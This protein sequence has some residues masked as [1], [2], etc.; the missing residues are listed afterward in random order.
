M[1]NTGFPIKDAWL[2]KLKKVPILLID[3]WKGKRIESFDSKYFGNLFASF[4]ENPSNNANYCM[5]LKLR[6]L[7]GQANS[8]NKIRY[9]ALYRLIR[10]QQE[11]MKQDEE[12]LI[13]AYCL[14]LVLR[15]YAVLIPL[16]SESTR[17]NKRKSSL[18]TENQLI[19]QTNQSPGQKQQYLNGQMNG[20]QR[21]QQKIMHNGYSDHVLS[22]AMQQI[23]C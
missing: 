2:I 11:G 16:F 15:V 4:M 5:A 1:S 23:L 10:I 21:L 18:S 19:Y 7:T 17:F 8:R 13:H 14:I 6:V 9:T 22:C 20:K 12:A 3:D